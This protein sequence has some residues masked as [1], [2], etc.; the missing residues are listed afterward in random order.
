MKHCSDEDLILHYYGERRWTA[1]ARRRH[2]DRC[3]P[4]AAKY[5]ELAAMLD[6][7]GAAEPPARDDSYGLEVWHRIRHRL[8]DQDQESVLGRYGSARPLA[9]AAVAVVLVAA[10]YLAGRTWPAAAPPAAPV[11]VAERDGIPPDAAERVRLSAIADHFERSE[12]ILLDVVTA[13]SD[14]ADVRDQQVWAAELLPTNRLYRDASVTAGDDPVVAV[15]DELERAL[16]ELVHGPPVLSPEELEEMR[17]RLDAAALL[18]KVRVLSETLRDR[19]AET[20]D[21]RTTT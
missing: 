15:L 19:E 5:G 21:Y 18:F 6:T 10:G 8:P 3:P 9:A 14:D 16:L 4:C 20:P 7:V 13:A 2:I 11:T 1:W 12:H 17:L